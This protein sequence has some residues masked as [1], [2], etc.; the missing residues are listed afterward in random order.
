MKSLTRRIIGVAA[1][2]LLGAEV[3]PS[4]AQYYSW[5]ADRAGLKWSTIK[6]DSVK[7]VYPDSAEA[8]ARRVMHYAD[9]V[10]PYE[11]YAL[12]FPP[13]KIPIVMRTENFQSNGLVMWAPKRIEFLSTPSTESYSMP[14]IK[15]LVAHEYRHAAQ[16]N[17][18]NKSTLKWLTYI[19]GQQGATVGLLFPSLYALEGDAVLIETQMSTYGRGL[20]PSFTMGYRALGEELLENKDYSKWFSGSYRDYVPDH[21]EMG[22]QIVSHAYHKYGEN[23]WNKVFEYGSKYPFTCYP[24]S[25]VYRK[26][27]DTSD[28]Q[29]FEETFSELIEFWRESAKVDNTATIVSHT[30]ST[31]YT[32]YSTPIIIDES[33]VVA[34]KSDYNNPSRF[35]E[36][37]TKNHTERKLAYTGYISTRPQEANGRIWWSEN[38]RSMLF[39]EKVDSKIC[40]MD[41]DNPKP[42]T[43]KGISN[44]LYPTPI[45]KDKN[46]IAYV[47]YDLSG[48]YSIVELLN[49]KEINRTQMEYPKEIHSLAWDNKTEELYFIVTDDDGMWIG[50]LNN[51]KVEKI[52]EAAYITLSDLSAKDGVLYFGSIASGKDEVHSFDL[53]SRKEY[54]LSTSKFGSFDG[55]TPKDGVHYLTTY[56]KFGYNLSR[57]NVNTQ[58]IEVEPQ[59]TP[60]NVV[61]LDRVKWDVINLDTVRFELNDSIKSEKKY[62]QKHYSKLGHMINIHSW[63]PAQFSPYTL[64][65]EQG[66]N[67]GIGATLLTQNLLSSCEGYFSYG[68][69]REQGS[70][71]KGQLTYD[72]LGIRFNLS[73]A[74]GGI[75]NSYFMDFKPNDRYKGFDISA[76]LPML[77]QSGYHTRSLSITTGW[78]YSNGITPHIKNISYDPS[79]LKIDVVNYD[80]KVGVN[81]L[82][83]G[84]SYADY[85]RRAYRDLSSPW[86][87]S[88]SASY[89][90][91]PINKD[92]SDLMTLYASVTT[93]GILPHNSL[94]IAA[95]YQNTY[96]GIEING[97]SLLGY[98]SS[99][100]IPRGY[101]YSDIN[102]RN[103]VA[104][105][106]N[107]QLPIWY[108]EGGIEGLLYIKRLSLNIGADYAQFDTFRRQT[109]R[110]YSL[111][112]DLSFDINVLSMPAASTSTVKIS[113]YKPF[114]RDLYLQFGV[115]VPF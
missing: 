37:D 13:M 85:V 95:A 49:K 54:Q 19:L 23:I 29:L 58:K 21:Y 79:T 41:L 115:R 8:T 82:I 68:C 17:N 40:F 107:Y 60:K 44:A 39:A 70:I 109:D 103:Y 30:D 72:G 14:W 94:S 73:G 112:G 20:Q 64:I 90:T 93:P 76:T 31:N 3:E 34:L 38:R 99:A 105:S 48:H 84:V 104:G 33:K 113:I 87:Y 81:K 7:I 50:G 24:Q 5:G 2:L 98:K 110:I 47:E 80:P 111:G 65:S 83:F 25:I 66:V 22:Y 52:K 67:I 86:G 32:T 63:A 92:F 61:N 77:F 62:K 97:V 106:L 11:G 53:E 4:H 45:G 27:Y 1:I 59:Q 28:F 57:Q 88:L 91:D 9:A 56:D 43:I 101:Y 78:G 96:G 74:Y 46:H 12:D 51:G 108:P 102:N 100:L 15:Q 89:S 35:I 75:Q 18:L 55:S 26:Y 16:Y 6:S 42:K 114:D 10:R 69:D 36:F 71:L